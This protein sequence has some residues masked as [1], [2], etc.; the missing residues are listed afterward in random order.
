MPPAVFLMFLADIQGELHISRCCK[1]TTA[2]GSALPRFPGKGSTGLLISYRLY[3]FRK[4]LTKHGLY[5]EPCS[6]SFQG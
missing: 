6:R 5:M 3:S 2:D 1:R 4:Y